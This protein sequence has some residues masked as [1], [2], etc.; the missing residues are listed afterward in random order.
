MPGVIKY[1]GTNPS[2]I[3]LVSGP[4]LPGKTEE[5]VFPEKFPFLRDVFRSFRGFGRTVSLILLNACILIFP[6]L[7]TKKQPYNFKLNIKFLLCAFTHLF[8]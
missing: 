3:Q 2:F 8:P 7:I 6:S 5:K 1:P 4:D